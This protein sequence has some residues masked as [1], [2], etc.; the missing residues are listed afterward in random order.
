METEYTEQLTAA[1]RKLNYL[2]SKRDY[3]SGALREKLIAA[4]FSEDIADEA[5]AYAVGKGYINDER[6]AENYGDYLFYN[7]RLSLFDVRRKMS[8]RGIPTDLIA[9]TA[10][11]YTDDEVLENIKWLL[12]HKYQNKIS[13]KAIAA[14][15]RKG[16]RYS[17]I[18]KAQKEI[19]EDTE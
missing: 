8:E 15:S 19:E 6:Y 5:I 4:E 17:E 7:R 1:K 2:L 3:S 12:L 11:K 16:Y 9:V 10:D 14:L 18:T 13:E